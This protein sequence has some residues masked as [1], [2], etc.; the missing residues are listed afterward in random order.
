MEESADFARRAPVWLYPGSHN[1]LRISRILR[2]LRLLGLP[3][4][5][6]ALLAFLEDLHRRHPELVPSPTIGYWRSR[7][8]K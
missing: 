4:E 6:A 8:G 3:E 2:C 7:G 5:A 1:F